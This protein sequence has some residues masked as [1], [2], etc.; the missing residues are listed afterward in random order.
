MQVPGDQAEDAVFREPY[1]I[2]NECRQPGRCSDDTPKVAAV[3][4]LRSGLPQLSNGKTVVVCCYRVIDEPNTPKVLVWAM[5]TGEAGTLTWPSRGFSGENTVRAMESLLVTSFSYLGPA[6]DYKGWRVAG[7]REQMWFE[8][9]ASTHVAVDI[10]A[11]R[12]WRWVLP[13]EVVNEEEVAGDKV[14]PDIREDVLCFPALATLLDPARL[15]PLPPAQ[16]GF[17]TTDGDALA[18]AASIGVM[19]GGKTAPFGNGYYLD[20]YERALKVMGR[21]KD[22]SPGMVRYAVV[23]HRCTMLLGRGSDRADRSPV[24]RHL[25]DLQPLVRASAKVR[26][27]GARWAEDCDSV[28]RGRLAVEVSGARHVMLP[29]TCV[30]EVSSYIP[31]GY[32]GGGSSASTVPPKYSS[33]SYT[34]SDD[35]SA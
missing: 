11:A 2:V 19:R 25:G 3:D 4:L 34:Q 1:E 32:C 20:S 28:S 13:S 27:G 29:R 15:T 21:G 17:H 33:I 6:V 12:R 24:T 30:R 18:Y 23:P 10:T 7:T 16:V 22:K 5:R 31:Q 35:T 8:L 9:K 14:D 26:D